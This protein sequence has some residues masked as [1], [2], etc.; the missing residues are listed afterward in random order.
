[1]H[2]AVSTS[3]RS[4]AIALV[5]ALAAPVGAA[6]P[7][8]PMALGV[9]THFGQGWGKV[10]WDALDASGIA[11]VRDGLKWPMIET[12]PGVYDFSAAR[13]GHVD[14]LCTAGRKF[15]L[16]TKMENPLYDDGNTVASA[17]ARAAF[18]R[19]LAALAVR[20]RG[21]MTAIEIGNEVNA[22]RSTAIDP[23]K[24]YVNILKAIYP[25]I[26][27][28]APEVAVLGGSSNTIATGY[29]AELTRAGMMDAVDGVA[30]HPYRRDPTNVDWEL[31]RLSAALAAAGRK[32][33]IWIT[34]FSKAF[35]DAGEA[36]DFLAKMV[37]LMSSVGIEQAQWYAL[38]DF[39]PESTM[40][41][42]GKGGVVLPGAEALAYWRGD[43]L[44]RGGAVRIDTGDPTLFHYRFG[45]D[46]QVIWTTSPRALGVTGQ[47][48]VRDSRGQ[49]VPM[50]TAINNTPLV[51]E[52]NAVLTPGA[53][54]VVADSLV[55]YGRAPW[56]Y[57]GQRLNNPVR[58]LAVI[59]WKWTS[60]LSYPFLR[61]AVIN[62]LGFV[63]TGGIKSPVTLTARYTAPAAVAGSMVAVACLQYKGFTSGI[64]F[65]LKKN[66]VV[67]HSRTLGI[68]AV[69]IE[70]PVAVTGGDTIDFAIRPNTAG[71]AHNYWYRYRLV[72]AGTASPACPVPGGSAPLPADDGLPDPAA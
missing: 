22:K 13:V 59:D 54:S 51:F 35:K 44:P 49:I 33:P 10:A 60:F 20:Y 29:L 15:I 61:P 37:T 27:A 43:V 23:A 65:D 36:P 38:M 40:G 42:Y 68:D 62:Q 16:V 8:P 28:A 11:V 45:S 30:V 26:K 67:I 14:R 39:T 72:R 70:Q 9:N 3:R 66:G 69:K 47:A 56:R 41:L 25:L 71:E 18:G 55:S 17:G 32:K 24:S 6:A 7:P 19:Y 52:G 31:Q 5:A 48:V 2:S 64:I 1:M 63:T 57:F 46:R 58:D 12:S 21:C 34:E 50:P 53:G 4:L